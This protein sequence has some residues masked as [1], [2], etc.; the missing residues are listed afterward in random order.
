MLRCKGCNGEV[1]DPENDL[2]GRCYNAAME[3]VPISEREEA[4]IDSS[5]MFYANTDMKKRIRANEIVRAMNRVKTGLR[6]R[7]GRS[8]RS[9]VMLA[10]IV[11]YGEG[12]LCTHGTAMSLLH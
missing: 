11:N 7:L 1:Q 10:R 8:Y 4:D 5:D 6:S 12:N 9:N 2:C 3:L